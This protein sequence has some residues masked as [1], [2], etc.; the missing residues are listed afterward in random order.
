[1]FRRLL[2]LFRRYARQHRHLAVTGFSFGATSASKRGALDTGQI[3]GHVD[4]VVLHGDR[5]TFTGW[6][7]AERITLVSGVSRGVTRPSVLR[8]DVAEAYGISPRVG[9]EIT[10][11]FGNGRFTL[12]AEAG[13]RRIQ[14]HCAP[15]GR[16]QLKRNSAG[17]FLR[18]LGAVLRA[19][20]HAVKALRSNDTAARAEVKRILGLDTR[21]E[22]APMDV[23]LFAEARGAEG[24]GHA[25]GPARASA[26]APAS[27]PTPA[28]DPQPVTIVLPVYNAFSL[29]PDVLARVV[30]NTDLPWHLVV[31]EDCSSDPEV[32]PWLTD[33]VGQREAE[34]PGRITLLL[35]EEN[36]GF[37]R[38]VNRGFA[39][40]LRRGHHVMLLNSDAFVPAGWA[41]RLLRPIL[42]GRDVATVTPMSNDAEIFSVPAICA[43]TVIEPG[44]GDAMDALARTFHPEATLAEAPT[45]VGFCMAMNIDYLRKVP[46]FD[47]SFGRGYGEE[48]DWCQKIRAMGGKH[49][50]LPG[51]FVE[52]RGG[53]SFGSE[54]KLKLVKK[55]N[56]T[57]ARRYP[58]YDMEVQGFIAADP[59]VTARVAL[60]VAWAM[61]RPGEAEEETGFPIYVAHSMGG[62]AEK[63]LE[64][65]IE[66]DLDRGRPSLVLRLGGPSRWQVE[67]VSKAGRVAGMTEDW[68]F[69]KR[70]LEPVSRRH[71]VYSCAVGDPDPAE[72][73]GHLLELL[74]ETDTLE[75]LFHDF[76]PLTPS[77]TLLDSD[78]CYRGPVTDDRTDSAHGIQ[79]PD[80]TRVTLAE[81][82]GAWGALM[83]RAD[84][85]VVFS[86]DSHLQ[87]SAAYPDHAGKLVLRPHEMLA[88][89]P[90]LVPPEAGP[91]TVAV[92]GNIGY[93][94]GAAVVADL[95]RLIE[96]EQGLS[97][98][99]IGNVDPAYIPPASVPVHGDYEIAELPD[100]AARYGITDWLIPSVWPE[101]F[102]FTTHEALA[103]GL[104]VYAFAIGAQGAAVARADNGRAVPF[105]ADGTLARDVLSALRD[106]SGLA[107]GVR[108]DEDADEDRTTGETARDTG[109]M[110]RGSVRRA[111]AS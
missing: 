62:G 80:G 97:L 17:L 87:V 59:L 93:Q 3:T 82:R 65:R 104:P 49:L 36:K 48:V 9:F 53:E 111:D 6:T 58:P 19:A 45:G 88:R 29:L 86:D 61:S 71:L 85:L 12:L 39:E 41:S 4:R 52:H 95:G 7:T 27:A 32:R 33:W 26:P 50:G 64:R 91:R 83:A 89:V 60:A 55:N 84:A 11:P 13:P 76:F 79:R 106:D 69:V 28:P 90:R 68:D 101:T 1:M 81:W 38:S 8:T 70:L 34:A 107:G 22:A 56:E 31:I 96:S 109:P 102:S 72:L 100:L 47:T 44:Q 20:P 105:D 57:I 92:L 40:A 74:G 25:S 94:K 110:T 35:N 103:T 14:H 42:A 108:P 30:E 15:I 73:P 43:R 78:G 10:Q 23:H 67:V 2:G 75:G 5:V 54:E 99:L 16:L 66:T 98:V 24:M 21:P 37:I 51:L 46:E 63:Y 77:Y 18:F